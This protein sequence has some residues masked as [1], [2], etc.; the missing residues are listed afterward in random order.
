MTRSALA[1]KAAVMKTAFTLKLKMEEGCRNVF[2]L[3]KLIPGK[4][5]TVTT[6]LL[7]N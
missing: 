7:G 1:D 4:E 5:E 6:T 2:C 3:R